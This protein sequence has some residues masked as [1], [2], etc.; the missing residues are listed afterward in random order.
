MNFFIANMQSE[1]EKK[2][3]EKK[4][5]KSNFNQITPNHD[6]HAI[7]R[8]KGCQEE[9]NDTAKSWLQPLESTTCTARS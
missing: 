8:E 6:T 2:G 5:K 9:S 7:Q 1:K 4:K 3:K